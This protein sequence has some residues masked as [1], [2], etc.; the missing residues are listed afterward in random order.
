MNLTKQ[1]VRELIAT[2]SAIDTLV[3]DISVKGISP[4]AY[5][6]FKDALDQFTNDCEFQGIVGNWD[7]ERMTN[8]DEW[9]ETEM[10][11]FENRYHMPPR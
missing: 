11:S 4:K 2:E 5:Q 1:V 10:K 8:V 6:M 3:E 9:F 7:S